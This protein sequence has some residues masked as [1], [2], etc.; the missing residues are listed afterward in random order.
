MK[1]K[2]LAQ[3][4]FLTKGIG[5]P[6]ASQ[7]GPVWEVGIGSSNLH[8]IGKHSIVKS[9]PST[10]ETSAASCHLFVTSS[11]TGICPELPPAVGAIKCCSQPVL[12][13]YC[14]GPRP[15]KK[16]STAHD[17]KVLHC[18]EGKEKETLLLTHSKNHTRQLQF[19]QLFVAVKV[20]SW[21]YIYPIGS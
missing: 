2:S 12:P 20:F 16:T 21:G 5:H 10:F 14:G 4:L 17:T 9:S 15:L 6:E 13:K 3:A 8:C 11:Q 19:E 7:S 1:R 18:H